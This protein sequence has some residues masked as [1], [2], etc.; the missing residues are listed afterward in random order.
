MGISLL[1]L[2]AVTAAVLQGLRVDM[3]TKALFQPTITSASPS[4]IAEW[5]TG[6]SL[7][8]TGEFRP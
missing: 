7:E 1:S 2:V 8:V 6:E 3:A 5:L 4:S